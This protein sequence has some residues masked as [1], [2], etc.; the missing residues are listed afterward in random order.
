MPVVPWDE[1]N[2][3]ATPATAAANSGSAGSKPESPPPTF[4]AATTAGVGLMDRRQVMNDT[5]G[6]E[7][8]VHLD[9]Q[10]VQ[11]KTQTSGGKR[12]N[13]TLAGQLDRELQA[14]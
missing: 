4:H 9:M 10:T 7:C 13:R 14:K 12:K 11:L 6:G 5:S 2:A 3:A 8:R 1:V